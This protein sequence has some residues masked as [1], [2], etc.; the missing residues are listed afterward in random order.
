[1]KGSSFVIRIL[2]GSGSLGTKIGGDGKR[3]STENRQ[4]IR[5]DG[6]GMFLLPKT[7]KRPLDLGV[8]GT[9]MNSCFRRAKDSAL[10]GGGLGGSMGRKTNGSCLL[11]CQLNQIFEM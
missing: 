4:G 6:G 10:D 11:P 1:M 2:K 5:G 8:G 7:E 9:V 3:A